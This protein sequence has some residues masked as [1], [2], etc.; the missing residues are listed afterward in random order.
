MVKKSSR[1]RFFYKLGG[2]GA[3]LTIASIAIPAALQYKS[4]MKTAPKAPELLN[5]K[6]P[7]NFAKL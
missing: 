6:P 3:L 1:V 7:I 5:K 4:I 2:L